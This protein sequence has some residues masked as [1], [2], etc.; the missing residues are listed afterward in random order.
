MAV[1]LTSGSGKIAG[2]SV[3]GRSFV[4]T[5]KFDCATNNRTNSASPYQ[6]FAVP[7]GTLITSCVVYVETAEGGTATLDIGLTD[8]DGLVDGVNL[9]ATGYTKGAGVLLDASATATGGHL[10][11]ADDTV[12]L[13]FVNDCD[14]A[15]FY[16]SIAG[17]CMGAEPN[18]IGA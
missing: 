16:V 4:M 3:L 12:D 6:A 10:V 1:D 2:P 5:K 7:A 11:T 8:T 9:N 13:T 17:F 14:A 18:Q 15:V